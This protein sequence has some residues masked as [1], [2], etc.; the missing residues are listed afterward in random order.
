MIY[1]HH[2]FNKILKMKGLER[3]I[4]LKLRSLTYYIFICGS[5]L[6]NFHQFKL[7]ITIITLSV[8]LKKIISNILQAF[9]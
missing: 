4:W 9:I 8:F 5:K 6:V 7:K 2:L 3:V 1:I